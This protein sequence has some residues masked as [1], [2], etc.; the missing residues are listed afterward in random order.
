MRKL[1]NFRQFHIFLWLISLSFILPF[2]STIN[3]IHIA[4]AQET[5]NEEGVVQEELTLEEEVLPDD[6]TQS[7]SE[8]IID[9]NILEDPHY[10]VAVETPSVK[11]IN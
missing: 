3:I 2:N 5:S 11:T 7:E 10:H 4:N 8:E 9:V 1:K 6:T